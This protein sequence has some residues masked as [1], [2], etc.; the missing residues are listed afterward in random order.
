MSLYRRRRR[1]HGRFCRISIRNGRSHT[2]VVGLFSRLAA[3]DLI[4]IRVLEYGICST[5]GSTVISVAG[6]GIVVVVFFW[7]VG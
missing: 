6:Y 1:R 7:T 5:T 3:L 4:Y 2:T